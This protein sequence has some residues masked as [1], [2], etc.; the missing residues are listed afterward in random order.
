MV[1]YVAHQLHVSPE[2]LQA[3]GHRIKTRTIHLQQV[4]IHL[5]FSKAMSPD[6]YALQTWLVER[7][8]EH[9]Q[10]T[11]L[12][13][14][15]CDELRREHIVRPGLTRLERL[16]A[17]A[18]QQVYTETFHRLTP[19]LTAERH[20]VLDRLLQS[21]PATGRSVLH[22]LRQ[23]ASAHTATQLVETLKKVAFLLAAGV[24]TWDL[25]GLNPNRVKWLAQLGWKTP[26]RRPVPCEAPM[27]LVT[28]AWRPY[29]REPDG[30]LSGRYYELCTL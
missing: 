7:A 23:D 21:D 15:A 19:L 22:W 13:Q 30:S 26:T 9:D 3:Y 2:S 24:A 4:Q 18:R 16:V 28:D 11:L 27:A 6:F 8:L 5:G 17:T 29:V 10:P 12:L 1:A 14:L 25:G 20:T